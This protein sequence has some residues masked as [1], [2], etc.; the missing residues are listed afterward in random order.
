MDHVAIMSKQFGDLIFKILN[1]EK[2]VESRWSKNK[3]SPYNKINFGD[4][5]YF[6]N[7]GGPV[8]AKAVVSK[9]LQFDNLNQEKFEY[10][11][12]NFGKQICLQNTKY[13]AWYRSKNYVT[14]IFLTNPQTVKP[15]KIDKSGF[16]SACAW[17]A[18]SNINSIVRY[19]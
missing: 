4:T 14:L 15:F 6:K 11:V 18:V 2:T 9:V 5:V 16:G 10:I 1:K 13:D 8:I 7:S 12:K 3:I 19:N 17:I